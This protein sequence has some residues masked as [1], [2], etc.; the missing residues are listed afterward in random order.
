MKEYELEVKEGWGGAT[1]TLYVTLYPREMLED[2]VAGG[3]NNSLSVPQCKFSLSP[4]TSSL[5]HVCE[6]NMAVIWPT[7]APNPIIKPTCLNISH[8]HGLP[9]LL[10]DMTMRH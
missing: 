5:Q 9:Q 7:P 10:K 6:P 8:W 2:L 3:A 1:I 4:L